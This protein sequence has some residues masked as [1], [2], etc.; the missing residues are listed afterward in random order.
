[1]ANKTLSVKVL[2]VCKSTA[3]WAAESTLISKGLLCIEFTTDGK[4]LAKVGDG[5][6]AYS[7]LPYLSDG[8]FVISDY[9]TKTEAD[10]KIDEKISELGDVLR[11]KGVKSAVSELPSEGNEVGDVWFVGTAGATTDNF[12]EYVWTTAGTWEF[13]GRVQTDVD[14]SGYAEVTYVDA[15]VK[16]VADRTTTLETTV[17]T[18]T[19]DT[20]I[21]ITAA[22][23]T[24]WDGA[25]TALDSKVDKEDGKG[26]SSN[27]LTDEL[28]QEINDAL[29]K[30]GDVEEGANKTVVDTAL[31]ADSTNPVDNKAVKAAIDTLEKSISESSH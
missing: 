11:V 7:G 23:R 12:G 13:L 2:H 14:L 27:D 28:L 6:T 31:S 9:Y 17:G 16:K 24:K 30:L 25:V 20:D 29:D 18:H 10:A 4:C 26:L 22:E 21:H 1:M 3:E 15:E 19:A 8:S 5:A